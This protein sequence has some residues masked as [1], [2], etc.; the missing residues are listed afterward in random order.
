FINCVLFT[1]GTALCLLG[2][3]SDALVSVGVILVNVLVSVVQEVRA[4]RTLDRIA[5]LTMPQV[6]VI[7]EGQPETIHPGDVVLGD[8]PLSQ[9][10]D[11]TVLDCQTVG[12]G[13]MDVDDSLLTGESDLIPKRPGDPVYS[14]SFCVA[15]TALYEAQ[16]VGKDSL[17]NQLAASAR[18]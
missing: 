2:R 13:Q 5:L 3:F 14:G 7:R 9:A 18:A 11:H 15:G 10:G 16:K 4:K 1:L 12:E 8:V 6:T 17:A